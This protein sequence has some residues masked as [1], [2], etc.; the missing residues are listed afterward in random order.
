MKYLSAI[1][2]FL[3]IVNF[4]S[5]AQDEVKCQEIEN[6]KAK[7]LYE[8]GIDKKYKKEERLAFLKEAMLLEPDYVDANF[9]F[10]SERIRTLSINEDKYK[11][12][13]PF[14]KKVIE[15]CPKYHSDPYY[16]LGFIAWEDE[17]YDDVVKYM[18][19]YIDFK[20]DDEKKFNKDYDALLKQ[21]RDMVRYAKVYSDLFKNK[22]PFDPIPVEGICTE[23][24]EYLPIITSDDE[25]MLFTR[26]Q[27]YVNKDMVYETDKEM[28]LFSYAIRSKTT[29]LFNKGQRMPYPFNKNGS[30]GGATMSI[31]NKHVFFTSCKD[32][33]G[34]T[35][36]CDIY[37]ADNINGEWTEAKKVEGIN[38]PIY[39]DSQPSIASDGKTLYFASDRKGGRGGVDLYVTV[40]DISSGIWSKPENLGPVINTNFDEKS[41]FIHSDFQ[42]LYFSSD[43]HPGVGGVDIFF[44]KKSEDGKWSEPKNIGIPINT[45]RDDLGFF[46]STDGHLGYFA[47]NEP[48]RSNGKSVGKYDIF[49]FELYKEARPDEVAFFR[50]KI[51]DHGQGDPKGFKVEVKDALTNKITEAMVDTITGNYSVVVNTKNKSDLII[52]VKKENY[53]FTSQLVKKDSLISAKP[54]KINMAVDTI[55]V[56]KTYTLNNIYYTTNSAD[57]D[58]SSTIVINEFAEFLKTNSLLKIEVHGHT[59]NIG[60]QKS[61]LALSTDRAFS[62]RELLIAKGI[63]EKRLLNFKGYGSSVPV[64]DNATEAGRAKNRRTEFVIIE[65]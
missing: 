41:A 26:K 58:P 33:G 19:Q 42:T 63:E 45:N 14:L 49:S 1:F 48:T 40:K 62:V 18:K 54:V 9:A 46:V 34:P 60:D 64:A 5:Y 39:W 43:G 12:V 57:L 27:P 51:E 17:N 61:N 6:K 32:E 16:Y 4:T 50:G 30:E 47:S 55:K 44:S 7:K 20:D 65:K 59:D 2:S 35:I 3:F 15:I 38:D 29:N 8:Q 24:D 11:P 13:E 23:K 52:T 56:G 22:V 53:A 28:E 36:N 31:D 37:T 21:A 25:M 10:A